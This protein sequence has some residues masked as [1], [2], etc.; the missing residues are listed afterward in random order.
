[1]DPKKPSS[2]RHDLRNRFASIRNAAFYLRTRV[3]KRTDLFST[4]P[5]VPAF[6][7]LIDEE[8]ARA[9]AIVAERLAPE[10]E[11]PAAPPISAEPPRL[12]LID[13]DE[14]IAMTLSALLEDEGIRVDT[15]RSLAEAQARLAGDVDYS[16]VLLDVNLGD[17]SGLDLLP[18]LRARCLRAKVLVIGACPEAVPHSGLVDDIVEKDNA[19]GAALAALRR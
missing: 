14:G 12:L 1:M 13:D 9:E 6:F 11:G 3:E 4:D 7:N 19:F 2:V 5:R 15:A 17:G 18:E 16:V 10:S 8:L